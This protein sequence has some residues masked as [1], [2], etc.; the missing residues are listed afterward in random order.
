MI[1]ILLGKPAF[2]SEEALAV[3]ST[4]LG[5][6]VCLRLKAVLRT[7]YVAMRILAASSLTRRVSSRA[8]HCPKSA[9]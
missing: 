8:A 2:V 3:F 5:E 4:P 7:D 1:E 6:T 9:E